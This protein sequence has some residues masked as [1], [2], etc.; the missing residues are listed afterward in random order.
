MDELRKGIG[1]QGWGQ[2][3]PVV[4]YRIQ[5]TEMFDQMIEDIK[6][7]V[8]KLLMNMREQKD[9]RRSETAKITKAALAS[10]NSVDGGQSAI[11]NP[12]VNRTVVRETPKVGRND[13]CPCGSG[14][15]YKNC[16]GR[17]A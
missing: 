9:L 6:F 4:Q 2:K 16:C 17:N 5:G 14:K 8:V 10:I 13:P 15:K 12:E 11:E 1:L 7:D 3:D